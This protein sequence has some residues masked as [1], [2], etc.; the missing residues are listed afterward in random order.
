MEKARR[1]RGR[2]AGAGGGAGGGLG[3]APPPGTPEK[4]ALGSGAQ[5]LREPVP[6]TRDWD[7]ELNVVAGRAQAKPPGLV[8][9]PEPQDYPGGPS[10]LAPERRSGLRD[11][12]GPGA[13][14]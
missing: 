9:T 6:G 7:P 2:G 11:A 10:Q 13:L 3:R 1:S 8:G 4:F 5:R 12:G 14:P